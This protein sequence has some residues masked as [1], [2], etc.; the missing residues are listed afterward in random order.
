[1]DSA[2]RV[3]TRMVMLYGGKFI[4]DGPPKAFRNSS[5]P[6]VAQFVAGRTEGPISDDPTDEKPATDP[7]KEA[8]GIPISSLIAELNSD[9]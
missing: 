8:Q 4:A 7:L 9:V 5:N 1:M 2:F 3:A 6:V